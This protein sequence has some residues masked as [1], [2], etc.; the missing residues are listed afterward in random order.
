V[1]PSGS[2]SIRFEFH[3]ESFYIGRIIQIV[4]SIIVFLLIAVAGVKIGRKAE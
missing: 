1:I 3:P 2:H 4:A